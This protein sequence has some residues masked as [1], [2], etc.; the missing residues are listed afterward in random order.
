MKT[1]VY[2]IKRKPEENNQEVVIRT[3][4][5]AS[6][7]NHI[8]NSEKSI[9]IKPNWV[10]SQHSDEGNV[11]STETIEGI[12]QYLINEAKISPRKIVVGDGGDSSSTERAMKLNDVFR[13]EEYGINIVDLNTDERVNNLKI[14]NSLAL[15]TVSLAKTAYDASCIISVP[16]LKTH[17]M[18]NTT[19]CLKNLM[20]AILPKGVMHGSL[21]K[22]I[23]D[24]ASLMQEKIKFHIVDGII[25][26]DGFELGGSPIRMDLIIAGA[27]PVAVDRVG[28]AIIGYGPK[29]AKYL[30]H[31]ESKGLGTANLEEIEVMG[32]KIE[33][34]YRKF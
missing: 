18:S 15:K 19:L 22:K 3:L 10:T 25:G 29:R 27:D 9:L 30:I 13:L 12:V 8:S 6:M 26:S 21:H 32:E 1:K 11:T 4:K 23:A 7:K 20:G 28:S 2:V 33:D 14:P 5:M 34:V 16:S 17:S 31:A 24:L